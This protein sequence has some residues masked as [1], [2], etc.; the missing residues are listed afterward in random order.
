[1]ADLIRKVTIQKGHDPRDFVIFAFGGA[2]RPRP[3]PASSRRSW[4]SRR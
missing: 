4:G 3:M 1:M 2:G